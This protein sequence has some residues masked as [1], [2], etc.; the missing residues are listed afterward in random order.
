MP[1]IAACIALLVPLACACPNRHVVDGATG[2]VAAAP[3]AGAPLRV[4]E[5]GGGIGAVSTMIQQMLEMLDI[6][7]P[8]VVVEPNATLTIMPRPP[9][10]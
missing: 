5:L 2:T 7:A 6:D 8:H 10:P 4:L 1:R 3:G 9:A